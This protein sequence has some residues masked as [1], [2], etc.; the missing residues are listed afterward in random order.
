MVESRR[1]FK[2]ETV[3]KRFVQ[4]SLNHL[5]PKIIIITTFLKAGV[6]VKVMVLVRQ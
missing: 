2:D 3:G 6:V 4:K 5:A 1:E